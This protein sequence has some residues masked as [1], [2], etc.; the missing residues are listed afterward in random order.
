MYED[1]TQKSEAIMIQKFTKKY[2]IHPFLCHII[3]SHVRSIA[4]GL[5]TQLI[6]LKGNFLL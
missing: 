1:R 4:T 3:C 2:M 5:N 6:R